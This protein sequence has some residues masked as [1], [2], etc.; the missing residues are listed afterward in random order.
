MVIGQ[1]RS[2]LRAGWGL[3]EAGWAGFA[4]LLSPNIDLCAGGIIQSRWA[5][6]GIT[7]QTVGEV[8]RHVSPVT[9]VG[10]SYPCVVGLPPDHGMQGGL[11]RPS[12]LEIDRATSLFIKF[13]RVT[14]A[15]VTTTLASKT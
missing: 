8:C 12:T 3:G 11:W 13:N 1:T 7:P 6:D 14:P 2:K 5:F 15:L 4:E 9:E 10:P